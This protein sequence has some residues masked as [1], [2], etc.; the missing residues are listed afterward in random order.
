MKRTGM[1][2]VAAL[3]VSL[4]AAPVWASGF[5]IYEQSAKASGQAGAW[6]ARADDAAANW[7]N[8]AAIVRGEGM[9][10]QFGTNLITVG[11]DTT[12]TTSAFGVPG[13][14]FESEG[15]IVTPSH[16]YLTQKVNDRWGWGIGL[17][18]PIGLVTEWDTLPVTLSARTS[19]LVTFVL[20]PN[21]AFALNDEWAVA[22]G[23]D[24]MFADVAEFSRDVDQSAL[25]A[26]APLTTVGKSDLT[27]DGDD[28]GWNVALHYAG[29]AVR[30]GLTYREGFEIDVEGDVE[31]TGIS[32]VLGPGGAVGVGCGTLGC[33]PNGGGSTTVGLPAQ[34]AVGVAWEGGDAWQ[35]EVDVAW[36]EWSAFDEL[37]LDFA[38]ETQL[39][40]APGVFV[41]VVSDTTLREDWDDTMSYRFGAAWRLRDQHELRFGALFDEAPVPEETARPSIPDGDRTSVTFGYGYI[42][43]RWNIDLYYMPLF[44]ED[45][46]AVAG[47]EG[48][49]PGTYE[50]FVHLAGV[51]FNLR[52]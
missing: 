27:G 5:S 30:F 17:N 11:S 1:W 4:A 21:V 10:F 52:F 12:F 48:V 46:D 31:F 44:F 18:N 39:Q 38:N 25:L 14:E 19:D 3:A 13:Q 43:E 50:S 34:A 40:V 2:F 33:F 23:L 15:S 8:P 45:Q 28:L 49:I 36:A 9:Q 35:F 7:Y 41:P 32:P 24:Y 47:E 16:F 22:I 37:A 42:G 29:D 51:T 6:V 26:Q 20:N